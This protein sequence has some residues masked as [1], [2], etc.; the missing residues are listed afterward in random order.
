MNSKTKRIV[1][2]GD[3][4]TEGFGLA[5]EEA[6]P[7]RLAKLLGDGYEVINAGVTAHCVMNETGPDGRV[8]WLPYVR[9][10]RYRMGIEARGD[11]YIVMLGTN[12]AQDG[13]LDDGSA[14]DPNNNMIS[15]IDRFNYHYQNILDD[16]R[17]S[18]PEAVIY[19]VYPVPVLQCIWPKHQQKYLDIVL[20]HLKQ[21]AADNPEV[22]V[23]DMFSVF[24]SRGREWLDRIYQQDGLHPGPEGAAL[25]AETAA[26]AIAD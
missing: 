12:D 26:A 18:S 10:D 1:C 16:I 15:R 4:I 14:I 11:V 25:I 22:R 9:T 7:Y 3:S 2:L 5:A 17:K 19:M 23:I 6:Y 20:E 8:M 24:Q 21:I 13:M